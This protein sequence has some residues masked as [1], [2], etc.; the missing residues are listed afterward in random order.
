MSHLIDLAELTFMYDNQGLS[1]V[2]S[3]LYPEN[4]I[5]KPKLKGYDL[6]WERNNQVVA[7]YI[8]DITSPARFPL[9]SSS[10]YKEL[11]TNMVQFP[12]VHFL[13]GFLSPLNWKIKRSEDTLFDESQ[14][15]DALFQ[16]MHTHNCSLASFIEL[17]T[18][19]DIKNHLNIES[20]LLNSF[21][22][23]RLSDES[24]ASE[25][26]GKFQQ[27][28]QNYNFHENSTHQAYSDTTR[29]NAWTNENFQNHAAFTVNS[30]AMKKGFGYLLD[31]YSHARRRKAFFYL[32]QKYESD[33]MYF[34]E[35]EANL[36]DLHSEYSWN[37]GYYEEDENEDDPD[38][39]DDLSFN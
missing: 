30:H 39:E 27:Y 7:D 12:R 36:A 8:S 38:E 3:L 18:E 35:I 21:G 14:S 4:Y 20:S 6:E 9:E 29:M 19:S 24:V 10:W 25:I 26:E 1:Q 15:T 22:T 33:E 31:L 16:N 2:N 13:T 17:R 11:A 34:A 32:A 28:L 37:Y 5:N 23:F